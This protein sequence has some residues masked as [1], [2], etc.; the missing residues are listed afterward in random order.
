MMLVEYT[1]AD[2]PVSLEDVKI[3]CRIDWD[4]EDGLIEG[5]IIPGARALAE[6]VSG[7]AIREARYQQAI[8]AEGSAA[9]SIGGVLQI[10]SVQL[11][12]VDV[13]YTSRIEARRTYITAPA[14]SVVTFKA[15]TDVAKH[16]G[17]KTWMLLICGWLYA[18]REML[19]GDVKEPPRYISDAL[20][21]SIA[22]P[23]GF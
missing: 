11:D 21:A 5:A 3:Q 15:G 9:L 20:L 10:E 19:G 1:A 8:P 14:G 16:P 13:A 7:C 6:G 23:S 4:D 18:N 22:V 2:E 12:G 17:V